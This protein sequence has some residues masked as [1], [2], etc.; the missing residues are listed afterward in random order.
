MAEAGLA[1][2]SWAIGGNSRRGSRTPAWISPIPAP[3]PHRPVE[4]DAVE[5]ARVDV[6]QEI[7]RR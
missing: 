4:F 6:A 3:V 1:V 7:A 2:G 5:P